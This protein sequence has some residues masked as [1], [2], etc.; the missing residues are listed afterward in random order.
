M[1]VWIEVEDA[2]EKIIDDYEKVNHVISL[3]QDDRNRLKG[4][5]MIGS[6]DGCGLELGSGPG[7]YSRMVVGVH[8]GPLVCLDFSGKMLVASRKRNRGLGLSYV[9]GVFEVLPFRDGAFSFVTASY[10]LRDSLDKP[11]A[12]RELVAVLA[13]GGRFLLIDIGKPDNPLLRGFMSVFMRYVVP[14]MGGLTAG[15]GYRN[16]WSVLYKT[17]EL[18]PSNGML[19]ALLSRHLMGVVMEESV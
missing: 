4:L 17:F 6:S 13:E 15:Y 12:V 1:T 7:N 11:R 9:A 5:A 3:F 18:L 2:L 19:K 14:V 8:D 10:A 16:P